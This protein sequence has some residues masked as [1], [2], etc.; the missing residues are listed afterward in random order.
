MLGNKVKEI[1]TQNPDIPEKDIES[2]LSTWKTTF[3]SN[4]S[5]YIGPSIN[6]ANETVITRIVDQAG[7]VLSESKAQ[8]RNT[9]M[10]AFLTLSTTLIGANGRLSENVGAGGGIGLTGI[11]GVDGVALQLGANAN[12]SLTVADK[13]QSLEPLK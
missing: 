6:V 4:P 3:L 11:A 1:T 2:L 8:N 7:K 12:A 9:S 13:N 10:G 5:L